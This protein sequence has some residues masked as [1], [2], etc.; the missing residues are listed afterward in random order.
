M[1]AVGLPV[2]ALS[3][4]P[5]LNLAAPCKPQM[6]NLH[7]LTV[8]R[9]ARGIP[10]PDHDDEVVTVEV[11]F[12]AG[13]SSLA[14]VPLELRTYAVG[15]G[16]RWAAAC[17]RCGR[18][19]S[20]VY[21]FGGCLVCWRCTGGRRLSDRLGHREIYKRVLRPLRR[22]GNLERRARKRRIHRITRER[23]VA[24][25]RSAMQLAIAGLAP[26]GLLPDDV[27][28]LRATLILPTTGDGARDHA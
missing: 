4:V 28:A 10:K 16:R 14:S 9:I 21:V 20:Y 22:A 19:C 17:P 3:V 23:L 18:S 24:G 25:A 15:F 1:T 8:E 7:R 11:V 13:S 6:E 27:A 5:A 12:G 26:L 2:S